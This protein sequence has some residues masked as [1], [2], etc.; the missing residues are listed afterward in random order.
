MYGLRPPCFCPAPPV[1][2]W[3]K[4]GGCPPITQVGGRT[5]PC[6][7]RKVF[8]LVVLLWVCTTIHKQESRSSFCPYGGNRLCG[9]SHRTLQ[10]RGFL[11]SPLPTSQLPIF[12][13]CLFGHQ[14][15]VSGHPGISKLHVPLPAHFSG[16]HTLHPPF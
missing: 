2:Q 3:S 14:Q 9:L 15:P 4:L 8:S 16:C 1:Q 5:T 10:R 13:P 12:R 7:P 11:H 6:T